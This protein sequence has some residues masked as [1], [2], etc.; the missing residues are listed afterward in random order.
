MSWIAYMKQGF[1]ALAIGAAAWIWV[2]I[3]LGLLVFLGACTPAAREPEIRIET[4][5][6][7]VTTPCVVN[8][9]EKVVP[10]K[11]TIRD[12]QWAQIPPGAKAQAVKA[13]A[14]RWMNYTDKLEAAT[15]GCR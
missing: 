5:P 8:R 3:M 10:L 13:Q 9:P 2:V 7:A 4:A 11:Q 6:V 15:A 14:G 1:S 12:A